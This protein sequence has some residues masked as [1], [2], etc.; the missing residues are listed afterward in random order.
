MP[1]SH[2][3]RAR[4]PHGDRALSVDSAHAVFRLDPQDWVRWHSGALT[5]AH[6]LRHSPEQGR[7]TSLPT[8]FSADC[9]PQQK[10]DP[11]F[12]VHRH[13]QLPSSGPTPPPSPPNTD[14]YA[15]AGARFQVFDELD[16]NRIGSVALSPVD[17]LKPCQVREAPGS[18][19]GASQ[20]PDSK[21]SQ[22]AKSASE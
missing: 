4:P 7:Y 17:Q 8:F 19:S 13:H 18:A 16:A 20:R 2:T 1:L 3:Q 12:R 6:I 5:S 11:V 9:R 21:S 14:T 15:P 10:P 22:R